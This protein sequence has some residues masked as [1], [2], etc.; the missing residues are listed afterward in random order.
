MTDNNDENVQT[1][2]IK[3]VKS[4]EKGL[5]NYSSESLIKS[6]LEKGKFF[7]VDQIM[8]TGKIKKR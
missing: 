1:F 4:E 3:V 8:E 6:L 2:I 5:S 7:R